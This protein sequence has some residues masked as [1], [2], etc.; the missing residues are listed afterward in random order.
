[1]LEQIQPTETRT[2]PLFNQAFLA[3]L[4]DN[5]AAVL[6]EYLNTSE[7]PQAAIDLLTGID[8]IRI[9]LEAGRGGDWLQDSAMAEIVGNLSHAIHE[10]GGTFCSPYGETN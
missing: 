10:L 9:N 1:M 6:T 2:K 5:A 4:A 3:S 8:M 7:A